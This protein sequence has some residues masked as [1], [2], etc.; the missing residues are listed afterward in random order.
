[1]AS[2]ADEFLE[3]LLSY[4]IQELFQDICP[5]AFSFMVAFIVHSIMR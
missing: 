2:A 4:D 5:A 3:T 1:M